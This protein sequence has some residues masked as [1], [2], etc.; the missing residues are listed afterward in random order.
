MDK[1]FHRFFNFDRNEKCSIE[2]IDDRIERIIRVCIS[3][4]VRWYHEL[5]IRLTLPH[6]LNLAHELSDCFCGHCSTISIERFNGKF[7]FQEL[8]EF[9]NGWAAGDCRLPI[10]P[11]PHPSSTSYVLSF[12]F[13]IL[14]ST[15]RPSLV[16]LPHGKGY[17]TTPH[18]H[19]HHHH[20]PYTILF[21]RFWRWSLFFRLF[22]HVYEDTKVK[23]VTSMEFR[24][25]SLLIDVD[26]IRLHSSKRIT[27]KSYIE[28]F[29][30]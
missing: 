29:I 4:C 19:H 8:P 9:R 15:V 1:I 25:S 26:S 21:Y 6:V 16:G 23:T 2:R 20:Q 24:S 3:V 5:G 14:Y 30:K 11:P 22:S 12:L 13:S 27:R 7:R 18:H 17:H 28:Y 10:P